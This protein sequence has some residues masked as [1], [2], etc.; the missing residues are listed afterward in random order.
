MSFIRSLPI[1]LS[2]SCL[3]C[4]KPSAVEGCGGADSRASLTTALTAASLLPVSHKYGPNLGSPLSHILYVSEMGFDGSAHT[5][6]ISVSLN[7]LTNPAR[8]SSG[9]AIVSGD[10][11]SSGAYCPELTSLA[12]LSASLKSALAASIN[13]TAKSFVALCPTYTS[14]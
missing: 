9:P 5:A 7:S 3:A 10:L 12:C 14:L 6:P 4:F 11:P 13:F 1:L 2:Y 8:N